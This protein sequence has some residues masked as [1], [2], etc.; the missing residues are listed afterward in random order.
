MIHRI[1][2]KHI[3]SFQGIGIETAR[4]LAATNAYVFITARDMSRG[5]QIVEEIKKST[6]NSKV[7]VME[8]DLTSLKSVELLLMNFEHENYPLTFLSVSSD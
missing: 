6:G 8:L 4:A 7:V 3:T 2:S 1:T 5:T